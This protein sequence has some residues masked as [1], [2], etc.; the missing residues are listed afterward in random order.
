MKRHTSAAAV[1]IIGVAAVLAWSGSAWLRRLLTDEVVIE[2]RKPPLIIDLRP[3][4]APQDVSFTFRLRNESSRRVLAKVH[5]ARCNCRVVNL[6]RAELG[7]GEETTLTVAN[8]YRGLIRTGEAVLEARVEFSDGRRFRCV[9]RQV[10]VPRIE[11]ADAATK[12]VLHPGAWG[13][14][15]REIRL[16]R[17][18]GEPAR[19]ELVLEPLAGAH[20]QVQARLEQVREERN[21]QGVVTHVYRLH[22]RVHATL[23][24]SEVPE[25]SVVWMLKARPA[26]FTGGEPP[27]R[28]VGMVWKVE[29]RFARRPLRIVL[30]PGESRDAQVICRENRPFRITSWQ[31]LGADERPLAP[32]HGPVSRVQ[33]QPEGDNGYRVRIEASEQRELS[34]CLVALKTDDE[35]EPLVVLP[36]SVIPGAGV[37]QSR[38]R[39]HPNNLRTF[40]R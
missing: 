13:E 39:E 36:V 38:L 31:L 2:Q 21:L 23:A 37:V 9:G 6:E 35:T 14:L 15:T 12:T 22:A 10:I 17:Y 20:R 7:P 33:W 8:S 1:V 27:Q 16:H 25:G 32:G 26:G 19:W 30:A 18:E 29:S 11:L 34:F 28:T 4:S 3:D 5:T 40:R 24:V